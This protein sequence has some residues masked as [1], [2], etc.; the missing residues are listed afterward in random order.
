ML[1]LGNGV[2]CPQVNITIL[3]FL[4]ILIILI[5]T[6]WYILLCINYFII[7]FSKQKTVS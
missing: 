6:F 4:L 7:A 1:G 2:D 3:G 5:L